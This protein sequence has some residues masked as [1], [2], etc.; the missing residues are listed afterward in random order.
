MIEKYL[1]AQATLSDL[2]QRLQLQHLTLSEFFVLTKIDNGAVQPLEI[3]DQVGLSQA[4]ISISVKKL[5]NKSLI[6]EQVDQIDR[7]RRRY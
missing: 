5:L 6:V 2:Q 7:R 3:R 4:V 1:N